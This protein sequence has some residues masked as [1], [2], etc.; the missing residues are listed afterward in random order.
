MVVGSASEFRKRI[1]FAMTG[2]GDDLY[3][4]GGFIGPDRWNWD[5]KPLSEVDVLTL[6]SERPTWRQAARMT[7]CHGTILGCTLLR[8]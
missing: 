3:V 7:R 6:G 1:G 5:I 2:L 8:I 4:I